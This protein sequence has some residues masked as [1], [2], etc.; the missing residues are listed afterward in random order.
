MQAPNPAPCE[1]TVPTQAPVSD[2]TLERLEAIRLSSHQLRGRNFLLGN[3]Q[4]FM[5]HLPAANGAGPR[6]IHRSKW[7]GA[8]QYGRKYFEAFVCIDSEQRMLSRRMQSEFVTDGVT[9]RRDYLSGT[10]ETYFVP[11]YLP[12][13]VWECS[14]PESSK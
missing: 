3:K 10:Q 4:G 1:G 12:A 8:S 2:S 6:T 14:G 13:I 11:D 7:Y 9:A 5:L